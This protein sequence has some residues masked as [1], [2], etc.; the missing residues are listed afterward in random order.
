MDSE[1][2][3]T[4]KSSLK[5]ILV[6]SKGSLFDGFSITE[7]LLVEFMLSFAYSRFLEVENCGM[8]ELYPI[9]DS[10]I[11][12]AFHCARTDSSILCKPVG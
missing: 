9:C 11:L 3:L 7:L 4:V 5:I 2:L 8:F 10:K 1:R 6:L 12:F